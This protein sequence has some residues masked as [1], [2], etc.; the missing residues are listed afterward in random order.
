MARPTLHANRGTLYIFTAIGMVLLPHK[1]AF[2]VANTT[3]IE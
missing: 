3:P 2:T 1:W